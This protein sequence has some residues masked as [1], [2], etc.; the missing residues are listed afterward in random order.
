MILPGH[1]APQRMG[2]RCNELNSP[3]STDYVFTPRVPAVQ[4]CLKLVDSQRLGQIVIHTGGQARF[5][6]SLHGIGGHCNDRCVIVGVDLGRADQ[7]GSLEPV[8]FRHLA[9][10]QDDAVAA[11]QGFVDSFTTVGDDLGRISQVLQLAQNDFLVHHVVF[12]KQN[13]LIAAVRW[14]AQRNP[15]LGCRSSKL[16]VPS[17]IRLRSHS[18]PVVWAPIYLRAR[19]AGVL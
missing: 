6:I 4:H 12:C 15:S 10:H 19:P 8:Q 14:L 18:L 11:A 16:N 13:R 9:V 5:A 3:S 2:Q 1:C 17:S 7:P